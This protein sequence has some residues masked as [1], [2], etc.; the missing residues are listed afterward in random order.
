METIHYVIRWMVTLYNFLKSAL[1]MC[2]TKYSF[3]RRVDAG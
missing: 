2:A 1:N 3:T